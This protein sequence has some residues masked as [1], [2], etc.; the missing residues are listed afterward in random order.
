MK[1]KLCI[2]DL[3]G[4]LLTKDKMILQSSVESIEKLRQHG[5]AVTIAS[6]RSF[7]MVASYKEMLSIDLPLVLCNGALIWHQEA[8]V[9]KQSLTEIAVRRII[10]FAQD[11]QLFLHFYGQDHIYSESV[12]GHIMSLHG[13]VDENVDDMKIVE[14]LSLLK[15]PCYKLLMPL[16][17]TTQKQA[18]FELINQLGTVQGFEA[19]GAIEMVHRNVSKGTGIQWMMSFLNIDA[20][21]TWCF[22]DAENDI[23]MF[24]NV[25][26]TIAMGNGIKKLKSMASYVTSNHNSDGIRVAVDEWILGGKSES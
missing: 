22:G 23:S 3:D 9:F 24:E 6:G 7:S 8:Y 5:Y 20:D 25:M 19:G 16:K 2:F 13:K 4:T 15:V 11:H 12:N 18:L 26:H 1:N 14:D 17:H 21:K 10:D